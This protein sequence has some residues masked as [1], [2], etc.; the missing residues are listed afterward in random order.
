MDID[1]RTAP[2]TAAFLDPA[3][4][5]EFQRQHF[6][7]EVARFTRYSLTISSVAF[8]A[9]GI[10]D[11]WLLG[12]AREAAWA[13]R[14][15]VF[16][17]VAIVVLAL[18]RTRLYGRVHQPLMLLFGL[19]VNVVVLSIGAIARPAGFFLYTAYAVLFV[20]L[21]PFIA[22]MNVVT[23]S[24]YTVLTIGLFVALAARVSHPEPAVVGSYVTTLLALGAIGALAAREEQ[25]L[26][27]RM[28]LQRKE[29][30]AERSKSDALLLNILPTTVANRLKAEERA[31]ADGFGEVT[32]LFA[33]LVG[34]T[35]LSERMTPK[36]LVRGLNEMF[37]EFDD[38]ADSLGVEKI[39]TI[40]DA[41]MAVAGLGG[42]PDH[43]QQMAE[44]ALG[45][46]E[47][48]ERF[49]SRFGEPLAV[50]IGINSGPV[51]AGV[52]GKKKFIY[53]VWGDTVNTA[54]R[55]ESH[56]VPG[57]IL[58]TEETRRRLEGAFVLEE[59]GEIDVKG[60]GRMPTW[61][62][63]RRGQGVLYP[64]RSPPPAP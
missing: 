39:K 48:V 51:V 46:L 52:I 28:F 32:V 2:I 36:D 6:E 20:T 58:V 22:K 41:Y 21:G 13:I 14:Y 40:G 29:I 23:Q 62:L 56:G 42:D 43:A 57:A 37:S 3:L 7:L 19:A 12:D 15:G 35:K 60:K 55:M 59:R 8:L 64:S 25:M 33:D 18:S 4:E 9:Y 27:R 54:S 61:F 1:P 11:A 31:I 34:F 17:P 63:R 10:H 50:R 44:M 45:M 16:V 38:L 30:D 47:R 49:G 5:A 26:A 53:D 24:V